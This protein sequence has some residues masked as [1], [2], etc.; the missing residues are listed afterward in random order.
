MA[1]KSRWVRT[2]YEKSE[3]VRKSKA[4]QDFVSKSSMKTVSKEN[5][6][7]V[8]FEKCSLFVRNTHPNMKTD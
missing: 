4:K 2:G 8:D 6:G 1:K 5:L 3:R 7:D